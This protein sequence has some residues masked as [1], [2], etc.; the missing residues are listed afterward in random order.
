MRTPAGLNMVKGKRCTAAANGTVAVLVLL[1]VLTAAG[2]AR[3]GQRTFAK[4]IEPVPTQEPLFVVGDDRSITYA[5]G[6]LQVLLRPMTPEAL[7]RQFGSTSGGSAGELAGSQE[8]TTTNPYTFGDWS[9]PERREA[10]P[11]FTV[12]GLQV[13][14]Y[15]YP[16]V[17]VDPADIEIEAANGRRY[18]ALS[19]S[20]LT[21]HY[22][23][24]AVANAGNAYADFRERT[25][26]LRRTMY[27]AELVWSGSEKDGYLVFPPLDRDVEEFTV[28][29]R[30]VGLRFDYRGEP[31]EQVDIPFRFQREVYLA[32]K[33]R[34]E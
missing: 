2:C 32:R 7:N 16:K 34:P 9:P 11:R 33:E 3:F 13:T 21:N 23:P 8:R 4:P 20:A 27:P 1:V 18:E 15:E 5:Q 26:I 28:W 10:P 24:F 25:D 12:F 29:V 17:W 31:V 30:N 19:L 6:R 22:W 14:N